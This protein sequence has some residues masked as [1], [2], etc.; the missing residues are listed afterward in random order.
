MAGQRVSFCEKE[1]G[2]RQK[3]LLRIGKHC[4][5]GWNNKRWIKIMCGCSCQHPFSENGES[6]TAHWRAHNNIVGQ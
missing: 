3:R 1:T 4:Y 6:P 2:N 5:C